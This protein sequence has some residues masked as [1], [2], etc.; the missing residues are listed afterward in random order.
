MKM[1]MMM[2]TMTAHVDLLWGSSELGCDPQG[3]VKDVGCCTNVFCEIKIYREIL[4]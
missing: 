2:M 4:Y 1:V 3:V